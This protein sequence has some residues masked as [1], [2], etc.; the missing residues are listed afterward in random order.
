MRTILKL[1]LT[2]L[3]IV[4]LSGQASAIVIDDNYIGSNNH[5][6]G[7]VIGTQHYQIYNMDVNFAGGFMNVRVNTNFDAAT[8]H[9]GIDFGDLFISVD[10]WS[11]AGSAPYLSDNYSNGEDWEFVF[12]TSANQLYGGDFTIARSEHLID[13]SRYIFRDGQEVQRANGGTAYAGSS[14]D[15]SHAGNGGYVEYNILLASLGISGDLNLGLKWGMTCANDTIE[16]EV[17]T[18]V[19]EPASLL[20]LAVGLL[21]LGIIKRKPPLQ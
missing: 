21:G 6:Y 19:P 1:I 16:G 5:G 11:P 15:L 2:A 9:Y 10:G 14:V 8:D 3:A 4:A 13:A 12:D 17:R 20:L 18:S 7:D